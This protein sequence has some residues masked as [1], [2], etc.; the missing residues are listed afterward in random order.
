MDKT[1]VAPGGDDFFR[2]LGI[3]L[4]VAGAVGAVAVLR[5]VIQGKRV[6]GPEAAA[7]VLALLS[8]LFDI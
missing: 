2:W 5:K 7:A 1:T 3:A 8:F 4:K 6:Q